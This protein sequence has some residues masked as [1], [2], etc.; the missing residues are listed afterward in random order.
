MTLADQIRDFIDRHYLGH[1]PRAWNWHR[2]ADE[3]DRLEGTKPGQDTSTVTAP[4][5]TDPVEPVPGGR[6]VVAEDD[7]P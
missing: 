3:I 6:P 5:N 7:Q 2:I 1:G 4:E